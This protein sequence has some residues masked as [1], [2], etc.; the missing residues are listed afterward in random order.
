MNRWRWAA[1][2]IATATTAAGLIGCGGGSPASGPTCAGNP[3]GSARDIAPGG[4]GPAEA[5]YRGDA[6]LSG[7]FPTSPVRQ[8]HGELWRSQPMVR[9]GRAFTGAGTMVLVSDNAG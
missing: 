7:A 4:T 5:S 1:V 3:P 9:P 2:A 8:L 6:G